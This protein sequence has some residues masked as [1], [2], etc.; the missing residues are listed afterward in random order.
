MLGQMIAAILERVGVMKRGGG[1]EPLLPAVKTELAERLDVDL[2]T[3]LADDDPAGILVA[4]YGFD[5]GNLEKFAE[6]LF[7]VAE[8]SDAAEERR[9]L[10]DGIRKIYGYLERNSNS[11]SLYRYEILRELQ[12]YE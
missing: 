10:A 11:V 6:L 1:G 3:L 7:D 8:A 4:R 12:N 5:D 2:D 9:R